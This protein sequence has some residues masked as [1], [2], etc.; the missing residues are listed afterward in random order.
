MP[1]QFIIISGV[2]VRFSAKDRH[3]SP[4]VISKSTYVNKSPLSPSDFFSSRIFSSLLPI[5]ITLHPCFS[6]SMRAISLPKP[7][8]AP[9]RMTVFPSSPYF[10]FFLFSLLSADGDLCRSSR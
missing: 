7:P 10:I 8:D 6:V 1:A 5:P 9:V 4:S 3:F 2:T